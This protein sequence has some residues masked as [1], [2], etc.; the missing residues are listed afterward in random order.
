M[1]ARSPLGNILV[2]LEAVG[3]MS[4]AAAFLTYWLKRREVHDAES[5]QIADV[6]QT[7]TATS[8]SLLE[9]VRAAAAE[10]EAK[11]THLHKQLLE[12]EQ[13]IRSLTEA[14]ESSEAQSRQAR[15]AL[16]RQL[17]EA[18]AERDRLAAELARRDAGLNG[19]RH[20]QG[21]V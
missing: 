2:T 13:A 5:K 16:E 15:E 12:A 18:V 9:P 10:A 19:A 4:G 14:L 6:A 7:L 17:A 1:A 3:G 20:G 8:L 11:A 21:V